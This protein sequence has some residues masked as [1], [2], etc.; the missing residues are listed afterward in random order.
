M[1]MVM[2]QMIRYNSVILHIVWEH[3]VEIFNSANQVIETL[4]L[5]NLISP[6][7]LVNYNNLFDKNKNWIN[8]EK[9]IAT[10]DLFVLNNWLEKLYLKGLK[11]R[12]GKYNKF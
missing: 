3:D 5:K 1:H 9:D 6:K 10:T 8:C 4:V 11:K 2:K 12:P 7:M